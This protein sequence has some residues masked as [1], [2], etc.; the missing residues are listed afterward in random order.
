M[1]QFEKKSEP[2]KVFL[3]VARQSNYIV[4]VL[5]RNSCHGRLIALFQPR[6]FA[7]NGE[8]GH[9]PRFFRTV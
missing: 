7:K 1:P 5:T 8:R 2:D 6:D 9:F 3:K 4:F